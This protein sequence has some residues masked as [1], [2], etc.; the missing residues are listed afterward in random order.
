MSKAHLLKACQSQ[1]RCPVDNCRQKHH[2][3]LHLSSVD[4]SENPSETPT[5][6][7]ANDNAALSQSVNANLNSI[8][9]ASI[10]GPFLQVLV[11]HV[12]N[13]SGKRIKVNALFDSSS[14]STLISKELANSLDLKGKEYHLNLSNVLNYQNTFTSK[15]V[16]FSICSDTHP[17][18]VNSPKYELN[19]EQLKS[20][21]PH[22]KNVDF[23]LPNDNKVSILIGADVPELHICYDVKQGQKN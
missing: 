11:I 7:N 20:E 21:F 4:N 12:L 1:F 6:Q 10:R 19:N 15:L 3:L 22:L 5:I 16:N 17:E 18:I 9:K 14:D 2:T 8:S 23:C 13:K